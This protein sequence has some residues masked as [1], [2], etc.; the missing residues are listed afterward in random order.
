M[1]RIDSELEALDKRFDEMGKENEGKLLKNEFT[2]EDFFARRIYK[3]ELKDGTID[4]YP[5][6]YHELEFV[7]IKE[8]ELWEGNEFHAMMNGVNRFQE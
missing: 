7:E 4:R 8:S 5:K 6:T 3:Q 1:T 2:Y